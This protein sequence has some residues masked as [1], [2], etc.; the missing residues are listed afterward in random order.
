MLHFFF[1]YSY[2]FFLSLESLKNLGVMSLQKK[3]MRNGRWL[4]KD[5]ISMLLSNL[6]TM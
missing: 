3:V 5:L 4:W 2:L 6:T 1:L